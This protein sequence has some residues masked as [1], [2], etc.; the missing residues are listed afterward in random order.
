V[1]AI[2]EDIGIADEIVAGE[3]T[4]YNPLPLSSLA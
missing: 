4:I 3:F 1:D 2:P